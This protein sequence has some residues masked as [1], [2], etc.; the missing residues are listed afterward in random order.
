MEQYPHQPH[1]TFATKKRSRLSTHATFMASLLLVTA[2]ATALVPSPLYAPPCAPPQSPSTAL[3]RRTVS[4]QLSAAVSLAAEPVVKQSVPLLRPNVQPIGRPSAA[5]ARQL[6][7]SARRRAHRK[8]SKLSP[9]RVTAVSAVV[10]VFLSGF[11][12]SVGLL[13]GSTS[14]VADGWH[15]FSDLVTDALCW[16]SVKL[17]DPRAEHVCTLGIA[18][19]LLATG[20]TMALHSGSSLVGIASGVASGTV[21]AAVRARPALDVAALCVASASV[22]SKEMLFVVTHAI[23]RRCRSPSIIANS[24]HHR[25]D[26]LSSLVAIVGIVGAMCGCP[27]LDPL[28]ATAVGLM[29]ARMGGE[30]GRESVTAL[31]ANCDAMPLSEVGGKPRIA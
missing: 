13:S 11:K 20:G 17:D 2:V 5:A 31:A 24:Y 4:P 26:A 23:G 19:V 8:M 29:V 9:A 6:V 18:G 22:A 21:E 10:N 25:S 1:T 30:V 12:V 15:S 3:P 7:R 28:A 16:L 14:L 27:W